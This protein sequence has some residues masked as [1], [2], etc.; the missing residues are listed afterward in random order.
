MNFIKFQNSIYANE[1]IENILIFVFN[2]AFKNEKENIFEKYIYNDM[3]KIKTIKSFDITEWFNPNEFNDN[4]ER[5]NKPDKLKQLVE[6][7]ISNQREMKASNE[8]ENEPLFCLL[9]KKEEI[10]KE[11]KNKLL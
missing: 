2:F 3:E 1:I 11:K 7:D 8:L 4:I 6:Y 10:K 5:L 9:K